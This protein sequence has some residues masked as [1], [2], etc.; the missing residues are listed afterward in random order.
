MSQTDKNNNNKM[1]LLGGGL[2]DLEGERMREI[3]EVL[4]ECLLRSHQ[5]WLKGIQV[6]SEGGRERLLTVLTS[7]QIPLKSVNITLIKP[8]AAAYTNSYLSYH[9]TSTCHVLSGEGVLYTMLPISTRVYSPICR[10]H[11]KD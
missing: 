10:F 7:T 6:S 3:W 8:C 11:C 4:I 2:D 9:N 5:M 1:L